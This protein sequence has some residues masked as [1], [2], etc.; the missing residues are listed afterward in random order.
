MAKSRD[1]SSVRSAAGTASAPPTGIRQQQRQ[2]T[3]LR[4]LDA[5]IDSFARLGYDGTNFREITRLCGAER[6]LVLYHYQTKEL[7]WKQAVE[8][9]ERRFNAAFEHHYQPPEPT[10]GETDRDRVRYAMQSFVETLCAVP[11]YGQILLREGSSSG[12]RMEWL[13]RHF[14]PR[15]ALFLELEDSRII[16]RI[17]KTVLRDILASTLVAF[18]ALGPLMERS[19]AGVTGRRSAGIHPLSQSRKRELVEYM[20]KLVFD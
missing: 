11:A 16:E 20:L 2:A 13:A 14:V 19:L 1:T 15:R 4:I 10:A 17:Q 12:P 18:V 5:A 3:R 9:V 6:P 7:L 8:E